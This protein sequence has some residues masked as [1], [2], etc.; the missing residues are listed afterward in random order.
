MEFAHALENG[1]AGLLIGRDAEGRIL[2][3]ELRSAT[4]SFS[5]SAFD[6]G[7]IAI[8]MTGSGNSIFRG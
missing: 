3:S 4:P 5:W 6:F 1:L 2:G 8:S 7:S